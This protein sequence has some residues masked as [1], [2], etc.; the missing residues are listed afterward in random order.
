MLVLISVFVESHAIVPGK[1]DLIFVFKT[2]A[3]ATLKIL[4]QYICSQCTLSLPPKKKNRKP[5][6]FLTLS[7]G[8]E[9]MYREQIG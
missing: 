4:I 8:S 5:Q 9:K 6:G 3:T 1:P 7:G 2:L